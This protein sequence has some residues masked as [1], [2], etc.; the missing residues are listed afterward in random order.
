MNLLSARRPKIPYGSS[1]YLNL[2]GPKIK[3][4]LCPQ[5]GV[6]EQR[7][8]DDLQ[9]AEKRTQTSSGVVYTDGKMLLPRGADPKELRSMG[10]PSARPRN[11]R[12]TKGSGM[13][14]YKRPNQ[15]EQPWAK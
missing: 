10:Q 1:K 4:L 14:S 7:S 2:Q 9:A 11:R 3:K 6:F 12:S 13:W 15:H 5:T 8:P